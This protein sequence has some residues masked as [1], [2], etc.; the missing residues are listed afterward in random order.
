ELDVIFAGELP[1]NP[2]ELM[3]SEQMRELLR[4]AE[5]EYEL[6]VID[7]PPTSVVA[8]AIPLLR[9][10]SGVLV[11]TRLDQTTRDAA[12]QLA[13]QLRNIKARVLGVVINHLRVRGFGYGYSYAYGYGYYGESATARNGEGDGAGS[14]RALVRTDGER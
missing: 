12:R 13:E 8:D 6:V 9:E 2:D 3:E 10:A 5:G 4:K 7:T 11:V 1:P 14:Q